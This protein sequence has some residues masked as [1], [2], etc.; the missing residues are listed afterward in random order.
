MSLVLFIDVLVVVSIVVMALTRGLERT[1][2]LV[3]F[4]MM[5]FPVESQIRLP[6]LFDLTTQRIIVVVLLAL[7]LVLGR[8]QARGQ[9][10]ELPLKYLLILLIAWLLL[11][12]ATSVVPDV[13]FK[14]TLSQLLDFCV[15][16]Y[17]FAKT[18][19]RV[20]TVNKICFAF[21]ISM[22]VCAI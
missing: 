20:E 3:A 19:S 7:Y 11:S 2:P 9:K 21:V 18:V 17:I 15:P 12:S 14:A 1:L 8:S 10:E 13:S 16:Y 4:L 6:G 22:F 5:L